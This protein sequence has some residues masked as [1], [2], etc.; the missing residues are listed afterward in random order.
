MSELK[1][2]L[3][4]LERAGIGHGTRQD[5]N[6]EGTGVQ[7]EDYDGTVT[8]WWFDADGKLVSVIT[9]DR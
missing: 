1:A 7:V 3:A 4:M 5:Y 6:P 2:F 8:D 9:C